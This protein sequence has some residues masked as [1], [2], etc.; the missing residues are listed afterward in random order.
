[1]EVEN[2][3]QQPLFTREHVESAMEATSSKKSGN[4][5]SGDHK[6]LK[7]R[8]MQI[9]SHRLTPL[10]QDWIKIYTPL[11]EHL[12]LQVR[13][14]TRSKCVELKASK[15]TEE[16]QSAQLQKGCDFL[17]A[18]CLGFSVDDAIVLL[19][20]QEVYIQSFHLKEVRQVL[21]F[22]KSNRSNY[23]RAIGRIAG[24]KGKT[25]FAIEN[26]CKVRLVIAGESG[27]IHILGTPD[28]IRA[29]KDAVCRLILGSPAGKV[30]S[31]LQIVGSRLRE[32]M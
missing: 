27:M 8:K 29:A 4:S 6:E 26:S 16:P 12:K 32:R 25:K 13:F 17:H 2:Q 15:E 11:V 24:H 30:Y 28:C 5:T 18:F 14:N 9:P 7:Y 23:A 1:M 21:T 20:Y 10:K 19:R 3:E 22:N 31:Q